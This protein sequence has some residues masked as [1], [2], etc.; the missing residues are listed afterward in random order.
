[1]P[2]ELQIKA[3]ITEIESKVD[4]NSNP[5]CRLSLRGLTNRY[6][7]VFSNSL[8]PETFTT[9]TNTPCNFINRQVL[10][11]Y[12]ELPNQDNQGTF[13]YSVQEN[14]YQNKNQVGDLSL[15]KEFQKHEARQKILTTQFQSISDVELIEE[16]KKR[17]SQQDIK[18]SIY[19]NQEHIFIVAK[20]MTKEVSFPLPIEIKVKQI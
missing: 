19:P 3:R 6:F 11:T 16:L 12:Q 10:I 14:I 15:I 18:L 20:D 4:K 7:Y 17:V 13:S 8:K 1:M 5:Y 9:L 2:Q